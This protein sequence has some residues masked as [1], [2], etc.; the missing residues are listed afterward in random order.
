MAAPA[1]AGAPTVAGAA[2][3]EPHPQRPGAQAGSTVASNT[4]PGNPPEQ[5]VQK[6]QKRKGFFRRLLDVFK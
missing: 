4:L 6:P 5:Q 2:P 1:A 3:V